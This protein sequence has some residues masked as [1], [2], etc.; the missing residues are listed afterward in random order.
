MP[1]YL[2]ALFVTISVATFSIMQELY[3]EEQL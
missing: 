2:F 3:K 1:V